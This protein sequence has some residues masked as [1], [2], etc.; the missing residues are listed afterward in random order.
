MKRAISEDIENHPSKRAKTAA[1]DSP[2]EEDESESYALGTKVMTNLRKLKDPATDDKEKLRIRA[3]MIRDLRALVNT[4]YGEQLVNSPDCDETFGNHVLN[5]NYITHCFQIVHRIRALNSDLIKWVIIKL[6]AAKTNQLVN[7]RMGDVIQ[8]SMLLIFR[9]LSEEAQ[10]ELALYIVRQLI[11]VMAEDTSYLVFHDDDSDRIN[12][13]FKVRV[14]VDEDSGAKQIVC[15]SLVELI[16]HGSVGLEAFD[17]NQVTGLWC[18]LYELCANALE[19]TPIDAKV[20]TSCLD[21][22]Q[23]L[24]H[25]GIW[26]PWTCGFALDAGCS[27]YIELLENCKDPPLELRRNAVSFLKVFTS[28]VLSNKSKYKD[29]LGVGDLFDWGERIGHLVE[30]SLENVEC[31]PA[32]V[33]ALFDILRFIQKI[34]S[35]IEDE[36]CFDDETAVA[37]TTT[38]KELI[39]HCLD[40]TKN[41][42]TGLVVRRLRSMLHYVL[43]IDH[44][45]SNRVNTEW[46]FQLYQKRAQNFESKLMYD[47]VIALRHTLASAI[48]PNKVGN[49]ELLKHF[50]PSRANIEH[51]VAI[52]VKLSSPAK[53]GQFLLKMFEYLADVASKINEEV[54]MNLALLSI[55]WLKIIDL[56]TEQ[57]HKR[58]LPLLKV[59]ESQAKICRQY[60]DEKILCRTLKSICRIHVEGWTEWRRQVFETALHSHEPSIVETALNSFADLITRSTHG[61]LFQVLTNAIPEALLAK[62]D[63]QFLS[64]IFAAFAKAICASDSSAEVRGS[65]ITCKICTNSEARNNSSA[66]MMELPKKLSNALLKIFTEEALKQSVDHL[67]HLR[68]EACALLW[69]CLSHN[70]KIPDDIIFASFTCI[71]D[72][73]DE[74]RNEFLVSFKFIVSNLKAGKEGEKL[75][76]AIRDALKTPNMN[77]IALPSSKVYSSFAPYLYTG[78]IFSQNKSLAQFCFIR[79]LTRWMRLDEDSMETKQIDTLVMQM[80]QERAENEKISI[81]SLFLRNSREICKELAEELRTLAF[82]ARTCAEENSSPE[83]AAIQ[84]EKSVDVLIDN[85]SLVFKFNARNFLNFAAVHVASYLLLVCDVDT[86]HREDIFLCL[87]RI[88]LGVNKPRATLLI[89]ILPSIFEKRFERCA[90]FKSTMDRLRAVYLAYANVDIESVW[91]SRRYTIVY[92]LLRS[93]A[94]N[95]EE[96]SKLLQKTLPGSQEPREKGKAD[97]S[98]T[99]TEILRY[100]CEYLGFLLSFRRHLEDEENYELRETM[101][102]SIAIII[103]TIDKNFL[104]RIATKVLIL[105]RAAT[106]T[107]GQMCWKIWCEFARALPARQRSVL[108]PQILIAVEPLCLEDESHEILEALFED[109]NGDTERR[110][111]LLP[112]ARVLAWHKTD[113]PTAMT[114]YLKQK[115]LGSSEAPM[116]TIINDAAKMLEAECDVVGRVVLQRILSNLDDPLTDETSIG[117]LVRALL[118]TIRNCGQADVRELAARCLGRIGAVDPGR[119][120]LSLAHRMAHRT[121]QPGT[122][123]VFVDDPNSQFFIYLLERCWRVYSTIVDPELINS[124]EYSLQKLLKTMGGMDVLGKVNNSQ[125]QQDLEPLI[126]T[127][128]S[129]QGSSQDIVFETPLVTNSTSYNQWL[130]DCFLMGISYISAP[131]LCDVFKNLRNIAACYDAPFLCELLPHA[132]IQLIIELNFEVVKKFADEM[133]LCI[134]L[135]TEVIGWQRMTANAVFCVLDS[136]EAFILRRKK[137]A[138][139]ENDKVLNLATQ[140]HSKIVGLKTKDGEFLVVLAAE[141]SGCLLRALRWCEQYAIDGVDPKTE[142]HSF[143]V[144]ERIYTALGDVDGVQGSFETIRKKNSPTPDETILACEAIGDYSEAMPLYEQCTENKEYRL[145]RSLISLNQPM[146]ALTTAEEMYRRYSSDGTSLTLRAIEDI[147]MEAAWYLRDWDKLG[148]RI[149]EFQPLSDNR[150]TSWGASCAIALHA[151]RKRD[152]NLIEECILASRQRVIDGLITMTME[153]ADAYAQSYKYFTRLHILDEI[154]EFSSAP[155]GVQ[156][157]SLDNTLKKWQK[158][159]EMVIQD[160][161]FL[162]PILRVRREL[163]ADVKS[164]APQRSQ[165]LLQSSRLARQA[166]HLQIAWTFLCEAKALNTCDFE[167]GAEEARFLFQKNSAPASI[168]VLNRMLVGPR[169]SELHNFFN[170]LKAKRHDEVKQAAQA[171]HQ[172]LKSIPKEI[173]VQY[174]EIQLMAAEYN[175]K[176]GNRDYNDLYP[177]YACLRHLNVRSEDLSYRIATF[178]DCLLEKSL[179]SNTTTTRADQVVAYVLTTYM[180]VL[181]NGKSHSLHVMPRML[182]IWLDY[183][184]NKHKLLTKETEPSIAKNINGT[185]DSLCNAMRKVWQ[186]VDAVLFFESFPQLISRIC[187]PSNSV[188]ELLKEILSGL[189]RA[190][191]HQCLWQSVAVYRPDKPT[192]VPQAKG[193]PDAVMEEKQKF[194]RMRLERIHQVFDVIRAANPELNTL[195][196]QYD[197]VSYLLLN[198]A[199]KSVSRTGSNLSL[200]KDFPELVNFFGSG[201]I[202]SMH[203]ARNLVAERFGIK[204]KVRRIDSGRM[205]EGPR[206]VEIMIPYTELMMRAVDYAYNTKPLS[207]SQVCFNSQPQG[208]NA[209]NSSFEVPDEVFIH[210]IVDEY[211]VFASM[212]KPKKFTVRG[213]DG[214]RYDLLAK[215]GD[216]LRKDARFNDVNRMMNCLMKRN[217]VARRRQLMVKTYTVVPLASEGG[218]MEWL[219]NLETYR[220]VLTSMFPGKFGKDPP[221]VKLDFTEF[222]R[223]NDEQSLKI[224]R[225]SYYPAHPLVLSDWFRQTFNDPCS[226]HSAR[227]AYVRSTAVMSM[228]GFV[229]GL[230]DRHAENILIDKIDGV[231][232]HVDYNLIFNKGEQLPVPEVVPFRLT[233]NMV[234]GLGPT[235]V[236]G[237]FRKSCEATLSVMRENKETLLT[238]I[239]TFVHDPLLEFFKAAERANRQS[240]SSKQFLPSEIDAMSSEAKERHAKN[241]VTLITRRLEGHI[242]SM[243][244]QHQSEQTS[245]MIVEG[246]VDRLIEMAADETLLSR[247]YLGWAPYL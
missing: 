42:Y 226:W 126:S 194:M 180:D 160:T 228:I 90:L 215:G 185:I 172:T 198:F 135:A 89:E 207:M 130:L 9:L 201:K 106:A 112:T 115:V 239:A 241:S 233:R 195:I 128:L 54:G 179:T 143:Y 27:I 82:T 45:K 109:I 182:T 55:P 57:Q 152:K 148:D 120:G 216:E 242:I 30:I 136:L 158:R 48:K 123:N 113:K 103:R 203:L 118:Y 97:S 99:L 18:C 151:V 199:D 159:S 146:L 229:M 66:T 10:K 11:D 16:R 80:I 231:T 6:L 197:Y 224:M 59:A 23:K 177:T 173:R 62:S 5:L 46:L 2:D 98:S 69:S 225:E 202:N 104:E 73:D 140:V 33:T 218:I 189:I 213:M 1:D 110:E 238:V 21:T 50:L 13:E 67:V 165:L 166:G 87:N 240:H 237:A 230:G 192:N 139:K 137:Q 24:F 178:Y 131:L 183:T 214:K 150:D 36:A 114:K 79:F 236:E 163:L 105:L 145:L 209:L 14:S 92:S 12:P 74:V 212:A 235:G 93:L 102:K 147:Q 205:G 81:Q 68:K 211:M 167:L 111:E 222:T 47:E 60:I 71:K 208:Q 191:P 52:A 75:E 22:M 155:P 29:E 187:H 129:P 133:E 26:R 77:Q 101:L 217:P 138:N 56:S 108:L 58:K 134:R 168:S 127:R 19:A 51:W 153:D 63:I 243:K 64:G 91:A 7:E 8:Q 32:E 247:M 49:E 174:A 84:A 121:K 53:T 164:Y 219:P 76:N 169:F 44:V 86:Y 107:L 154:E 38:T 141:K 245:P 72:S 116:E 149:E 70:Y 162:E 88:C 171:A 170:T 41:G 37:F 96:V 186:T 132:I 119:V 227:L 221:A 122:Q 204:S 196:D 31:D 43:M 100:N 124:A 142:R 28:T 175:Q 83:E 85:I 65:T 4:R 3:E 193:V 181:R 244:N 95:P 232:V 78:A 25:T 157:G 94:Y 144:L 17:D 61:P 176:A 190:F 117:L 34:L 188:F 125:C 210:E 20:L 39:K 184:E 156:L 206:K 200:K 234:D 40:T 223:M 15:L 220:R 161:S 35:A 246:Q